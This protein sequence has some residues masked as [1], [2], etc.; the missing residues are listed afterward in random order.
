MVERRRVAFTGFANCPVVERHTL[1]FW[2]GQGSGKPVR[3][4]E[5]N[6]VES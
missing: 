1:G 4:K 5:G 2:R 6:V 3:L